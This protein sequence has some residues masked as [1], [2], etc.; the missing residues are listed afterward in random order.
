LQ[1]D[2]SGGD[3]GVDTDAGLRQ[4]GPILG[5][6]SSNGGIYGDGRRLIYGRKDQGATDITQDLRSLKQTFI[7]QRGDGPN[8]GPSS[9]GPFRTPIAP[10]GIGQN[11]QCSS[12]SNIDPLC[13]QFR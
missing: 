2:Q 9:G 8:L 13:N 10:I 6:P 11:N 12:V 4:A 7:A 1:L 3:I 5:G